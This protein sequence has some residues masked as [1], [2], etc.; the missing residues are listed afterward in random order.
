MNH[1]LR[2]GLSIYGTRHS[3]DAEVPSLLFMTRR[4][5]TAHHSLNGIQLFASECRPVPFFSQI[6][7]M[8]LLSAQGGCY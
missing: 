1:C 2:P 3:R 7:A 8:S 5:I 4:P 6:E